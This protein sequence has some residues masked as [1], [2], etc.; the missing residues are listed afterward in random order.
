MGPIYGQ[1]SASLRFYK[2]M[3]DW[4]HSEGFE[5]GEN[6][7]CLFVHPIT[8]L[9]VVTW[10]DDL[11][12]RGSQVETEKF[13]HRLGLKFDMKDPSYLTPHSPLSFVG[14][15]MKVKE[16]NGDKVYSMNQNTAVDVLLD[17]MHIPYN[18]GIKCP[19]PMARSL[20]VDDTPL[21]EE[22]SH[23]YRSV[24]GTLNYLAVTTRYDIAHSVSRLGQ[25][26]ANPTVSSYTAMYR[27][28][29]YMRS[30]CEFELEGNCVDE[31]DIQIYSDSDHAGDRPH[32]TRSQ[33]GT[34]IVLNGVPV[35]WSS[36][37]QV[38]STAYSSAVAEIYAL[39]ETVRAARLYAW[40]CEEMNMN[41]SWPLVV[42]VDNSQAKTF[43]QGTC[44]NS[45]I[46]GVIDMRENWVQELRDDSKVKTVH[47]PG[48]Q[49][50][51]NILTKCMPNWKFR[52]ELS[53]INGKQ[54]DIR[55]ANFMEKYVSD[56]IV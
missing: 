19:M 37:K 13:Y 47:V 22:D 51:A 6:E 45:K 30:N 20:Y 54:A 17:E 42:Q 41:V 38:G 32:T 24:V 21:S 14:L 55:I 23:T 46:R 49:N 7:P 27:L 36:R 18:S 11:M 5:S 3:A 39:S 40:R 31:D 43:Q 26:T 9:R 33:T 8:K 12:L 1:R 16:V 48:T 56:S 53:L 34:M 50:T 52:K 35:H 25:F 28:L 10:V 2:T 4:L 15:D 44:V 29:Q